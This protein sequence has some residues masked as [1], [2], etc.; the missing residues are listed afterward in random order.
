LRD[1]QRG[2]VIAEMSAAL[3]LAWSFNGLYKVLNGILA[4]VYFDE[5]LP[6]YVTLHR[7][8]GHRQ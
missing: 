1:Y 8:P 5:K 3:I 7:M 4:I 6:V 2:A